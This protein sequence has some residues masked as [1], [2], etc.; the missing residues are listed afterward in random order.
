MDIK[1]NARKGYIT[2]FLLIGLV[3]LAIGGWHLAD[4]IVKAPS[5]RVHADAYLE[6]QGPP[7]E[8]GDYMIS[9][10][11]LQEAWTAYAE[12]HDLKITK[13]KLHDDITFFVT[14]NY[15]IGTIFMLLALW[16]LLNALP[17]IGKWIELR[18]GKLASKN[19]QEI[20]LK[21]VTTIDKSRWEK[22]GIAKVSATDAD[23]K[24]QT[25]IV[26]DLM[27]EREPTDQI[28]AE[29]ERIAGV[30]KITGGK[31][32]AEYEVLKVEKEAKRKEREQAMNQMEE[33]E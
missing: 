11:D 9:D 10:G 17:T 13:P 14:Y 19:G 26:D 3:A 7:N 27:Y 29:I 4:A 30:D 21:D 5:M 24:V 12:Q 32:E 6:M 31:S 8:N 28:M 25:M 16:C 22:K 20:A 1:A 2:K 15:F 18:D 23:G 33:D